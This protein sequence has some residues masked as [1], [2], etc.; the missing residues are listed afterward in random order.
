MKIGRIGVSISVAISARKLPD[1]TTKMLRE[2][3]DKPFLMLRSSTA[4]SEL[5]AKMMRA[6][7]SRQS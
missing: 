4:L 3:P 6:L 1:A 7:G 2:R 5:E